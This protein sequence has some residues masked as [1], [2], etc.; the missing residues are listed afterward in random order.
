MNRTLLASLKTWAHARI[1]KPLLLRGA[2]Q[3]GKTFVIRQ[4]GESFDSFV[5]LNFE[6]EPELSKCF[7]SL[8]PQDIINA[9]AFIRSV[10]IVPGKTLLFLDEIQMCPEAIQ[11]L[12]YFKEEMPE[13][14]VIAAGSLLEFTLTQESISMP[15]GRIEYVYL[16]PCSFYEFLINAKQDVALEHLENITLATVLSDAAHDHLLKLFKEYSVVGGMPEAL[17]TYQETRDLY[18]VQR[19]QNSILQTYRDDFGKYAN[20]AHHKY[21]Q[22]VYNQVPGMVGTQIGY[23]KIE[24]EFRSRDLKNAIT[25]LEQAG[26]VKRIYATAA[27]GLPL[28]ATLQEKKFKLHFLDIGLVQRKMGLSTNL[29]IEEDIFKVN[30]GALAEQ[31][32]AQELLAY[33]D[34]FSPA[35]L[36]FW[37]RDKHNAKAEVDF[38]TNI[39]GH[40][41]PIEVKSGAMGRLKS[42]NIFLQEHAVPVGVKISSAP[43]SKTGKILNVPFYLVYKLADLGLVA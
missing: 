10:S 3:V 29:L 43:L 41:I 15:V 5:E 14:H 35:E 25:L 16:Y 31:S 33:Q 9:I 22:A 4:L 6:L 30:A 7:R 18:Q 20:A 24:P 34:P 27:V 12:R 26:V 11:A 40:I 28:S 19:I 8:K 23:Q 1:R 37:A 39:G 38:I 32:V 2:R 17:H 21:L 13:L 42:L 36:Y